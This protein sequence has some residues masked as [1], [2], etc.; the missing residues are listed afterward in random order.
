[1]RVGSNV[2][3]LLPDDQLEADLAAG[4]SLNVQRCSALCRVDL[5]KE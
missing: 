1:L 2:V 3:V 5:L 4:S